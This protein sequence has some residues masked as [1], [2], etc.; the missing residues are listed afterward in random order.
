VLD[1]RHFIDLYG[2]AIVSADLAL[3]A[4]IPTCPDWNYGD[5]I[6]HIGQVHAH[7]TQ[8]LMNGDPGVNVEFEVSPQPAN[9]ELRQWAHHQREEMLRVMDATPDEQPCWTWWGEPESAGAVKRHQV[10]EAAIH[11]ADVALASGVVP[12]IDATVAADGIPE[13]FWVHRAWRKVPAGEFA[14]CA[15][16]AEQTWRF[17]EGEPRVTVSGTASELLLA[18]HKRTDVRSLAIEGSSELV[19]STL[20]SFNLN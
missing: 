14:I 5:L 10:Q 18:L 1:T 13:L 12:S 7:W 2:A 6:F 15:T 16:D 4:R 19:Q 3:D 9:D 17:G 20:E 8:H 11:Y